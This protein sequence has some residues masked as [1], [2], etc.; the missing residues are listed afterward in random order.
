MSVNPIKTCYKYSPPDGG[1]G[2]VIVISATIIQI[3]TIVPLGVFGTIFNNF[4]IETGEDATSGIT[5]V[6]SVY[7]TISFFMGIIA[8]VLL[9][10]YS[11]RAVSMLG[12]VINFIGAIG[13]IF[14]TSLNQLIF[15]YGVLQGVGFGLLLPAAYSA[16]NTYFDKKMA[17]MMSLSQTLLVMGYIVM[18][19]VANWTLEQYG[20][21]GTILLLA[22]FTGF[23]F[24]AS[25]TF[26][27][28][29]WYLKKE[30]I[31]NDDIQF[32]VEPKNSSPHDPF[33]SEEKSTM[34]LHEGDVLYRRRKSSVVVGDRPPSSKPK[35][36]SRGNNKSF[37]KSLLDSIDLDLFTN[38]SYMNMAIGLSL[39]FTADVAF[40]PII[41]PVMASMGFNSSEIAL[42][43]STFFGADL[44][45]R[46]TLSVWSAFYPVN[47]R[48]LV[49][50]SSILSSV[51]RIAFLLNNNLMYKI[52]V[53]AAMGYLRCFI[54]SP[55]SIVIS[56][57]YP[58]T[59]ESAYCV[60]MVVNGAITLIFGP[61]MSYIKSL[62]NSDVWVL[63][64]LT[65]AF[66]IMIISWTMEML[67][68]PKN[69]PN[70]KK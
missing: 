57:D 66:I 67:M 1:W 36:R 54:Q 47:S 38:A 37:W 69:K 46:I 65:G 17:F 56:D 12:S 58:D 45:A 8:S 18:P 59:F 11:L 51:F 24:P 53:M 6:S 70:Y 64:M 3:A 49:L 13:T 5:L 42:M 68:Y 48:M 31:E 14:A 21:R 32:C 29:K 9:N 50:G 27:P 23:C 19:Y 10:R 30:K 20:Y 16:I 35:R 63:N 2:H 25:L 52:I 33:L 26:Q 34:E 41:S 55:Q 44:A 61:L 7:N 60:Y 62:T 22:G 39:S 4:F 28:V 40:I 43:I 15:T